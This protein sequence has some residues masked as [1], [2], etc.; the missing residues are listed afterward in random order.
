MTGAFK[1]EVLAHE[2]ARNGAVG[3]GNEAHLAKICAD[4]R[5]DEGEKVPRKDYCKGAVAVVWQYTTES[6]SKRSV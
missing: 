6:Q 2:G 4:G 1:T 3:V 5:C